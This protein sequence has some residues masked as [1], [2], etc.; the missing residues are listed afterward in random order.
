M[1]LYRNRFGIGVKMAGV[2]LKNI[3]PPGII[4]S[5]VEHADSGGI[6]KER[7]CLR[8]IEYNWALP[9]IDL[10]A[11]ALTSRLSSFKAFPLAI[12]WVAPPITL[13][14]FRL[15]SA[16]SL[17]ESSLKIVVCSVVLVWKPSLT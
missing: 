9:L 2:D 13:P 16:F 8:G 11:S 15:K 1:E 17:S 4:S 7:I 12:T 3:S 6:L 14:S 10:T 5:L